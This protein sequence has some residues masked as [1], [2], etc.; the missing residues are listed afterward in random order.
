MKAIAQTVLGGVSYRFEL[1]EKD[2]KDTLNKLITFSNPPTYCD[3]C[4]TVGNDNF[5]LTSNKDQEGNIYINVKC[6]KCQAKSKLGSYKTGGYFWH[7]FEL[8]QKKNGNSTD[9]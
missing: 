5:K 2:E 4:K 9:L 3:N 7:R 1:D 6:K 8:Y